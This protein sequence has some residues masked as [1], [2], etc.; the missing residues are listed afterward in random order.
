MTAAAVA[1]SERGG[2][3]RAERAALTAVAA[4][5]FVNGCTFASFVP[6]LPEVR[7]ATGITLDRLGLLQSIAAVAGFVGNLSV[8][9][10]LERL[11]SRRT[12]LVCGTIL[13]C[14]LPL[15]G[16]A[17]TQW[18]LLLGLLVMMSVDVMVDVAMNLQGSWLSARRTTP[19]MNR[20]HGLWSLG[21]LCGAAA[22]V[23]LT[24]AGV[25]LDAHL[26][27]AAV[28]LLTAQ[29]VGSRWLLRHDDLYGHP[30]T[31]DVAATNGE[32]PRRRAGLLGLIGLGVLGF[33]GVAMEVTPG[34]WAAFR[35]TDD[36][37]TSEGFAA[38]GFAAVAGGMTIGRFGGDWIAHRTSPQRLARSAMS[39]AVVGVAVATLVPNR[40]VD[41][42]GFFVAGLGAA[43]LLPTLYDRA[44]RRPGRP[45]AGLAALTAGLRVGF[46]M[47]PF[48]TGTLAG[49]SLEV[50]TAVMIVVAV[51][52]VLFIA[53]DTAGTRRGAPTMP[54]RTAG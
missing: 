50:G 21:S 39:T 15:I 8:S 3:T 27:V 42:G 45:G 18:V 38:L 25:A 43:T 53:A 49:T 51:A 23:L 22:G 4:Q 12:V 52:A 47:L 5:F 24:G 6:R 48:A 36:L 29:W 40:F 41:L 46:L 33:G 44:A 14:A 13:C 1:G 19:V 28:V 26:V 2:L 35:F 20:L 32:P 54:P 34:D 11:G 30:P 31:P 9:A 10:V 37:G 17:E 16:F 7:D